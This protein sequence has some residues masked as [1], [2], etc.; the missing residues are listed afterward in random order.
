MLKDHMLRNRSNGAIGRPDRPRSI[1]FTPICAERNRLRLIEAVWK[2][3]ADHRYL[4]SAP[5]DAVADHQ[6]G[7]R[8]YGSRLHGCLAGGLL[9]VVLHVGRSVWPSCRRIVGHLLAL[10]RVVNAFVA[11]HRSANLDDVSG[12]RLHLVAEHDL[13]AGARDDS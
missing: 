13:F 6:A 10:F 4:V 3:N 1:G 7:T 11:D 5:Y 12:R 2:S 8:S 9:V